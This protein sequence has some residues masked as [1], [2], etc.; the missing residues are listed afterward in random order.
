MALNTAGNSYSLM[1]AE[2][3]EVIY[4]DTNPNLVYG[5]KVKIMDSTAKT[6]EASS[7]V[8]TAKPLNT[9]FIRVPLVGEVVLIVKAPS[10][11]ASSIRMTTDT[12]YLDIVSL[13]SSI[14]HNSVPTVSA[15]EVKSSQAAGSASKYSEAAAG[16]TN[17]PKK[18]E[19]DS[20]FVENEAIKPLQPY[21][22]DVLLEGRYGQSIRFS[23]T[24][25]SGKFTVQPKWSGGPNI[26]P[27]TIIRNSKQ[28]QKG[29]INEFTTEDFTK[30]E[31]VIVMASGQNI[32]F[33]QYSGVTTSI[34]SKG[35][36]SWKDESWGTTPQM[37]ISSGRLV[38]N[39]TQKEII[40]FAKNGIALSSATSLTL[41][42]K[43]D[44]SINGN[45]IELG[46]DADEQ[47]ILG[48]KWASWMENL[49]DAIGALT[50]IS[51]VGPCTPTSSDPQWGKIESLKSQIPS[52]LSD[53]A[54]TK[55]TPKVTVGKSK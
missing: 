44:V 49:I 10:S 42:A 29:R 14:H 4:E 41:D 3:M 52:L 24:P 35:L 48:N 31:N 34:D 51:P 55:K 50:D 32:E 36:T 21:I 16:N 39:S 2:V 18:A 43:E 26:A 33:E 19:V 47:L 37:L 23:T 15:S 40:A 6:D 12:Y 9:S 27:I 1:P 5:L 38:F 28:D 17:T 8:I 20:N 54:Y 25:K 7:T 30:E 53:L 45:K 22:G 46:T 11:Y 13:Q